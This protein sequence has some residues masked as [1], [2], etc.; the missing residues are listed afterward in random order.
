M[1]IL[2][3][4][5]DIPLAKTYKA[6]LESRS[7]KVRST[8][9]AQ[10]AVLIAD[11]WRP[12]LVLLELQLVAHGGIEFLYEFRS[13]SDWQSIPVIVLSTIPPAEFADTQQL[14]RDQLGI[15]AYLYKP[16]T[17]LAKLLNAVRDVAAVRKT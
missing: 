12:D 2:L 16:R 17:S 5:P 3:I 11:D 13:Y 15:V 4:E 1:N 14:L 9:T 10:D 8:A 6:A 7:H